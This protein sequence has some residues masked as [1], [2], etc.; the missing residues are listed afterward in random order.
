MNAFNSATTAAPMV[1]S[2]GA[3]L[4]M[5]DANFDGVKHHDIEKVDTSNKVLTWVVSIAAASGVSLALAAMWVEASMIAFIAF[6]FPLVTA[7]YIVLQRRKIQWL[8]ST[9]YTRIG[10]RKMQSFITSSST[11]S[12]SF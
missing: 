10:P 8:P 1:H 6:A 12:T 5:A 11:H 3:S 7:P 9:C 2:A 4:S